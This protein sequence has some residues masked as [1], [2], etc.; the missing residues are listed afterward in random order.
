[1]VISLVSARHHWAA[2]MAAVLLGSLGCSGSRRAC[3][4]E[5]EV[6]VE[7]APPVGATVI[8]HPVGKSDPNVP[9]PVVKVDA[10]GTVKLSTFAQNDGVPPGDYTITIVWNEVIHSP[11]EATAVSP[12]DKLKGRY[13]NPEAPEAP[14][15][16][17]GKKTKKLPPLHL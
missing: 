8:F 15:V 4:V 10:K 1:M 13:S 9:L 17:V 5:F 14:R 6:T 3:P 16:T 11:T 12:E 2:L 7:G